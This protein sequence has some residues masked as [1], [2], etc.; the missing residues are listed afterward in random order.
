VRS[1]NALI[2]EHE[3]PL[4]ALPNAPDEL[5]EYIALPLV[6]QDHCSSLQDE[7]QRTVATITKALFMLVVPLLILIRYG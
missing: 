6:C 7:R 2:S 5:T 1:S 3:Q 4:S